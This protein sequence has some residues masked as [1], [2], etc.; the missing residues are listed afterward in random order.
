MDSLSSRDNA[1]LNCVFNPNL[2]LEESLSE[3][4]LRDEEEPNPSINE[5]KELEMRA[6]A[7]SE[8]GNLEEALQL[9]NKAIGIVPDKASLYNN[10]CH[11]YQFQRKF[12]EALDDVT[13]AINLATGTKLE[14]TLC[15]AHIQRGILHRRNG[16]MENAKIDFQVAANMGSIF[17]KNQI[18]EMNPYAALCNQMLRQVMEAWK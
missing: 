13:K 5:V 17:A 10:R 6:I 7:C 9:L 16:D 8:E 15:Q 2:P 11:V 14:K 12:Q 4:K 3:K 18:V 1:I